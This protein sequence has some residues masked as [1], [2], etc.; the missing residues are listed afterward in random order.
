MKVRAIINVMKAWGNYQNKMTYYKSRL[1]E[2]KRDDDL[3]AQKYWSEY[4]KMTDAEIGEFLDIE[5]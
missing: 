2:A 4:I 1:E 3:R 5:I